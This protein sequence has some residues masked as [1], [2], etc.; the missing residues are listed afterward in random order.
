MEKRRFTV[1]NL[2]VKVFDSRSESGKAAAEDAAAKI[3]GAI[4]KKGEATVVFAAAP[5]QNELLAN[6]KEADVNWKKVRALH[7]D[8]YVGLSPEHPAGFGNFLDR[9]IFKGRPFM[10]IHY[11]R[12][13]EPMEVIDRYAELLKKY[14]PDLVLLGVGENGHLAFNDPA[15]ADFD[16]PKPIKLV[17]LDDVCRQQ[18]V[19]DGCFASFDEVPK[20]ALT[21]TMSALRRIPGKVSAVPGPTKAEAVFRALTGPVETACP[22]SILRECEPSTLYLDADSAARIAGRFLEG[23]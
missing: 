8:E 21:L 7:M 23:L 18:Q 5:S 1:G 2:T 16:D 11:L 22:A 12:G 15:A 10:E 20:E 6:L 3:N 9:A 13:K 14:P 17:R 4:R 19:N